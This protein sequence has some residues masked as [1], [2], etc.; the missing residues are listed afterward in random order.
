MSTLGFSDVRRIREALG[1]SQSEIATLLGVSV[2]AVQSYE[3]GWRPV[4]SHV[5]KTAAL[6]LFLHARSQGHRASPCWKVRA[7][8]ADARAMC[9]AYELRAGDICWLVNGTI[10]RGKRQ[11]SWHAK[12]AKCQACPVTTP[13]LRT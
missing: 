10:C 7:C 1:K 6:L 11:K 5:Q 8:D 12:I 3:Q 2:R 9:P 13:W 4:P